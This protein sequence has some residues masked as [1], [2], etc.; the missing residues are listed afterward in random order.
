MKNLCQAPACEREAYENRPACL[1]H[2][3][4]LPRDLRVIYDQAADND[5][6]TQFGF[7]AV[8]RAEAL[9]DILDWWAQQS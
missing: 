3:E 2:W 1:P 8:T 4:A 6:R 9:Q 5:W 7:L